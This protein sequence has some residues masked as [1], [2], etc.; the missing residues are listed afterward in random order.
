MRKCAGC[1]VEITHREYLVCAICN[2]SYDIM[3]ANVSETRF[4]GTMKDE[5]KKIWKCQACRC[6]MPKTNNS[7]TPV[8]AQHLENLEIDN[9]SANITTR[10][11]QNKTQKQLD[12][13]NK[14]QSDLEDIYSEDQSF[15]GD[16]ICTSPNN[17]ENL[18]TQLF[19]KFCTIVDTKLKIFKE[20]LVSELKIII[21]HELNSAITNVQQNLTNHLDL[22]PPNPKQD[23]TKDNLSQLNEKIKKLEAEKNKLTEELTAL[24]NNNK[25]QNMNRNEN[26][27]KIVL[28]GLE[29]LYGETGND[30]C[31][32]LKHLFYDI[33]NVN[34][35]GYI[36]EIYRVGKRGYR[37]PLVVELLSKSMT[38][39]LL[40]N[41]EHFKGTGISI[42][43]YLDEES[44][45]KRRKLIDI[46]R[47]ARRQG[48]Y[49]SIR[50]NNLYINGKLYDN[51]NECQEN[52]RTNQTPLNNN[53]CFK[54]VQNKNT[55]E[56][57]D[58]PF[59]ANK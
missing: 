42:T 9:L 22:S 2:E 25:T 28:H 21:Q 16:T 40:D 30:I 37:R 6:K 27:R 41:K 23:N 7:N 50:N 34:L 26:Q 46:L 4:Y 54:D 35:N 31:E 47:D 45:R 44:L 8:R 29:E 24:Q 10:K 48:K 32:R 13:S 58:H 5:H 39:Y 53:N 17:K 49:A 57:V 33:M 55:N 3:C 12:M 52:N 11:K 15:P 38:R 19:D 1:L 20:S 36:E 14:D 18:N 43:E 59:R 56:S 51:E